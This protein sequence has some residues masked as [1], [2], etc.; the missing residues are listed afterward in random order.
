MTDRAPERPED[1]A[2][3][4]RGFGVLG[5]IAILAIFGGNFLFRPLS[6]ILVL[7]W[8]GL[9]HTPWRELGFVRPKSWAR[10]VVAGLLFG[11]DVAHPEGAGCE[12]HNL[13]PP[14]QTT[15]AHI[16]KLCVAA[17]PYP[18][19]TVRFT[20]TD[21]GWPGDV[22]RSQMVPEK[23]AARGF[24]VQ[25]TSDEAVRLAVDALAR[26]VFAAPAIE[27]P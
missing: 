24:R 17:S 15:V 12:I 23:L 6:A 26:E 7:L 1:S 21:R 4:L 16:A 25:R 27:A 10:T 13:A 2:R 8:A 11:L 18:D 3:D 20:G 9:S 14:D 5:L 19:A 22:P